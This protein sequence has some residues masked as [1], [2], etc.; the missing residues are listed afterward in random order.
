MDEPWNMTVKDLKDLK[1]IKPPVDEQMMPNHKINVQNGSNNLSQI[2]KSPPKDNNLNHYKATPSRQLSNP[3]ANQADNRKD[4]RNDLRD[5]EMIR[6]NKEI[7]EKRIS[8]ELS[9]LD[10]RGE[11]DVDV[12]KKSARRSSQRDSNSSTTKNDV[13]SPCLSGVIYPLISEVR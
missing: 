8:R 4:S 6:E 11:R 2:A 12:E 3:G 5:R 1:A 10:H 13:R 9:P 7:R